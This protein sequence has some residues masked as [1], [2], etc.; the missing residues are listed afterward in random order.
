MPLRPHVAEAGVLAGPWCWPREGPRAEEWRTRYGTPPQL[1]P[2]TTAGLTVQADTTVLWCIACG[3]HQSDGATLGAATRAA[4]RDAGTSLPRAVPVLWRSV[5]EGTAQ[6]PLVSY[7]ASVSEVSGVPDV[8]QPIDGPSFGLAF[9]LALASRVLGCAVPGDVL[10]TATLDATGRIGGVGGLPQKLGG[11]GRLAPSVR[12]VLVAADQQDEAQR[13]AS[14]HIEV[15]GVSH[16][17]EAIDRVFGSRLVSRL[18][19]AGEDHERREELTGSFF[20]LALM[21]SEGLVDWQPVRRGAA[22]ALETWTD[23]S[24]DARYRLAL[25]EA[26]AARHVDN[27]G[28]VGLPPPGWLDATPRA[29]RVQVVAHL[30]QQCADAGTP[31]VASIEPLAAALLDHAL[32]ESSPADLRLRGAL[33]RVQA[34]TGRPA[35]ALAEQERVARAFA[36]IYADQDIAYPLAEWARLAGALG[37]RDALA[38]AGRL[39]DRARGSGGYRGLGPRYVDLALAKGALLLDETDASARDEALALGVDVT[40]PDTLRWSALRWAGRRGRPL[41]QRDALAGHRVAARQL[42]L[43]E[44]DDALAHGQADAAESCVETLAGHDPGPVGHLRRAGAS[45]SEVARLYPY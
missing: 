28:R 5:H 3:R 33:A 36:A 30:V 37:D 31:D 32:Q 16:A 39:H 27:G 22:L 11:L 9:G 44:L 15:I 25:A 38:R 2:G 17:A 7:L 42:V 10:A 34:V 6:L 26:V 45:S 4:W 18:V 8:R 1:S 14:A 20:R 12:R 24:E 43:A 35:E 21:G 23:I 41:L 13:H 40:L 19:E 29:I